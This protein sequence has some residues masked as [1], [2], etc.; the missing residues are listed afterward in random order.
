MKRKEMLNLHGRWCFLDEKH[1]ANKDVVRTKARVHP[2]TGVLAPVLVSGDFRKS[3][4]LYVVITANSVEKTHPVDFSIQEENGSASTF[5]S[6]IDYLLKRRFF[7]KGD[8]L[9]MDNAAIHTGGVAHDIQWYLWDFLQDDELLNVLVLFLPPR[10][11]ELNPIELIFNIL[12]SWVKSFHYQ[13]NGIL[14]KVVIHH[15]ID[16][17]TTISF[18]DVKKCYEKCGYNTKL[19]VDEE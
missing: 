16:V 15:A 9:V 8:V 3:F 11:P 14:D 17:L 2:I 6:F 1:I 18:K 19:F 5:M 4:N 7:K 13:R 10:C 12:S